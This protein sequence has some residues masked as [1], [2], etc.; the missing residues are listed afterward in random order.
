MIFMIKNFQRKNNGIKIKLSFIMAVS[1]FLLLNHTAFTQIK[2]PIE[3]V[4]KIAEVVVPAKDSSMKDTKISNPQP[5]LI[6]F[7][8][9]YY[10]TVVEQEARTT[11]APAKDPRNP[12][13]AEKIALYAQWKPFTANSGTYEINGSTITRHSI[14]AKNVNAMT[15]G[16]PNIQEFKLEDPNTIWLLPTAG[17]PANEPRIKL[18]RLE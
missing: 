6:I 3:G 15:K 11:A 12:T 14:V 13:D 8:R 16:A 17:A 7:T 10:S 1:F 5:G 18:T 9:G 4:W 2:S